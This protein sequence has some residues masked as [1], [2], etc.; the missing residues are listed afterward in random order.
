MQTI[1]VTAVKEYDNMKVCQ[2]AQQEGI[3]NISARTS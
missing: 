3:Y 1:S 2:Y